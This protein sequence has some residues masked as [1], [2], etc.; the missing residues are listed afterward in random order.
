MAQSYLVKGMTCE[1]CVRAVSN[2]IERAIPG[3]SVKV[4]L[5]SG[6]VTVEGGGDEKTIAQ[7]ID[8]AGFEFGGAAA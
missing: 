5:A 3:A 8:D 4:D 2:A 7:A 6:K 1:G